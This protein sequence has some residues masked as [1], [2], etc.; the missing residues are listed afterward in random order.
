M[1]SRSVLNPR[2]HVTGFFILENT[3]RVFLS[4][5]IEMLAGTN[6][7]LDLPD[8]DECFFQ[9]TT[10]QRRQSVQSHFVIN[11]LVGLQGRQL[12]AQAEMQE[13]LK[14]FRQYHRI[15]LLENTPRFSRYG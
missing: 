12:L 1:S 8:R 13:E 6:V 14:R 15:L 3:A 5:P 7:V 9:M 11:G 2:K 10:F 4:H